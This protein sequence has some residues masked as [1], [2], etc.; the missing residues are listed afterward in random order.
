VSRPGLALRR[1]EYAG[2]P[3]RMLW[4]QA[5]R[6]LARAAASPWFWLA[7]GT[8][9]IFLVALVYVLWIGTFFVMSDEMTYVKGAVHVWDHR[10]P[11]PRTD[12]FYAS[13]SQLPEIIHAPALLLGNMPAAWDAMRITNLV[14]WTTSAVAAYLIA[15][16]IIPWRP[17][18]VAAALLCV[19]VPWLVIT[20][21]VLTEGLAYPAFLWVMAAAYRSLTRASW[22]TDLLALVAVGIAIG[23]RSQLIVLAPAYLAAVA[24]HVAG[25]ALANRSE[26]RAIVADA[27]RRHWLLLAGLGLAMLAIVAGG[28]ARWQSAL[29]NYSVT[30]H[31]DLFPPGTVNVGRELLGL[32]AIGV[33]GLPLAL[34]L[35]YV[36]TT[37]W[38]ADTRERH[39]F[40]ALTAC[41]SLGVMVVAASFVIRFSGAGLSE[42]YACY[43]APLLIL[44]TF[45]LLT[46]LRRAPAALAA[47]AAFAWWILTGVPQLVVSDNAFAPTGP[48]H[49]LLNDDLGRLGSHLPGDPT[50]VRIIAI[51][52][53]LATLAFLV[54]RR[55]IG[56]R[57][58]AGVVGGLLAVATLAQTGYAIY[59]IGWPQHKV[60]ADYLANRDWV[61][62]TVGWDTKVAGI[63]G[64]AYEPGRSQGAWWEAQFWNRAVDQTYL[65]ENSGDNFSQDRYRIVSV[66]HRTGALEGM[67]GER[68]VLSSSTE[69]RFRIQGARPLRNVG[70]L[71]VWRIPDH[72]RASWSLDGT[73]SVGRL[74]PGLQAV[75][76]RYSAGAPSVLHVGLPALLP[77]VVPGEGTARVELRTHGWSR[78]FPLRA[79]AKPVAVRLPA[80]SDA[81]RVL[82]PGPKRGRM[83]KVTVTGDPNS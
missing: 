27:A 39:A 4:A 10:G 5:T 32:V 69:Q 1:P 43:L 48:F 38:R 17:M 18:A 68:Y 62:K 61:D 56:P 49:K 77:G 60:G 53:V 37:F 74:A 73:D 70:V 6:R 58:L 29:G 78:T 67:Q 16:E 28:T 45:A 20:G 15:R 8:G 42:R 59:D 21:S 64:E 2:D 51:A 14:A 12:V 55:L 31:G 76:R 71:G 40:A 41:T 57:L 34:G 80:G 24:V 22:R 11:L 44:A 23:S 36:L 33:G 47:G 30:T 66:D 83:V 79:G 63:I 54:P 50:P 19:G 72:P 13:V 82:N 35:A 75:Y 7:L 3:L 52:V 65:P 25:W 9:A 26:W 46:P 81:V